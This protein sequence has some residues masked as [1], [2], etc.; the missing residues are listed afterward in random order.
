MIFITKHFI[1]ILRPVK[2]ARCYFACC[3]EHG[4]FYALA[5][6]SGNKLVSQE[7]V[8]FPCEFF[9]QGDHIDSLGNKDVV[10]AYCDGSIQ[11]LPLTDRQFSIKHT[12]STS[13]SSGRKE[14]TT[15]VSILLD[16]SKWHSLLAA[17]VGYVI[18]DTTYSGRCTDTLVS[19]NLS[20]KRVYNGRYS[21]YKDCIES[22]VCVF[23]FP[24]IYTGYAS[25]CVTY[26]VTGGR[27]GLPPCSR[28]YTGTIQLKD[29]GL[30]VADSNIMCNIVPTFPL[31]VPT[32]DTFLVDLYDKI[33]TPQ[34]NNC[35]NILQLKKWK[36]MVPPIR[37]L[38]QRHNL[39][40]AAELYLWWKYSFST[41]KMDIESYFK[42]ISSW[43]NQ[44]QNPTNVSH[45]SLTYNVA[46]DDV[47]RYNVYM[48]PYSIGCIE[49]LGLDINM[50]NTWDLLPFSFVLDWFVSV[51]DCLHSID[52]SDLGS[53]ISLIS[54]LY[55]R[56]RSK[57]VYLN[58]NDGFIGEYVSTYYAREIQT[59]WPAAVCALH[60]NNPSSHL[61]DAT[62]LIIA[63]KH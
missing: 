42:W 62:S 27:E 20:L 44:K 46:V 57:V 31:P 63:N 15:Y 14:E 7:T 56:K 58:P 39:K 2:G 41:S 49:F 25:F 45:Y 29:V 52:V 23:T 19:S 9:K 59:S 33:G 53:K 22:S 47:I 61:L 38:M 32:P 54:L 5:Q 11:Q 24:V 1:D 21:S 55:S 60:F 28:K 6:Y 34:V 18:T 3:L 8:Q 4:T 36:E 35:E 48:S 51:G 43:I 26:I 13:N 30:V 12:T 50:S 16:N 40:S 37:H 10:H 17:T